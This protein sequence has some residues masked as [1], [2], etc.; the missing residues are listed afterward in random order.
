[1]RPPSSRTCGTPRTLRDP[2]RAPG[3]QLGGE[4]AERADHPRLDQLDLPERW[5]LQASISAGCGIAVARRPALE[6]VRDEALLA[7]QPDL[8]SSLSSSLPA[9]PTNGLPCLS[10][11]KPGRLADEHQV[12]VGVAGAEHDRGAPLGQRALLAVGQLVVEARPARRGGRR[13]Q[14][15]TGVMLGCVR[16][17]AR[18]SWRESA[19]AGIMPEARLRPGG[20][21]PQGDGPSGVRSRRTS[22]KR[23][24]GISGCGNWNGHTGTHAPENRPHGRG[25]ARRAWRPRGAPAHAIGL[26]PTMGVAARGPPEPDARGARANATSSS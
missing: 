12:G 5:P 11:W 8:G 15:A 18:R 21:H 6:H 26:V 22:S 3:Q 1:M 10:S 25:A 2:L 24:S 23:P 17:E 13:R 4:V 19:A 7:L 16:M 14:V 9:W 20:R